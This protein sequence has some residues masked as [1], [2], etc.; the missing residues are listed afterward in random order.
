MR[1]A[2]RSAIRV[3]ASLV[4]PVA[5][6]V[7]A[8]PVTV[9]FALGLAFWSPT[10]T[11]GLALGA[12]FVGLAARING[13][14]LAAS[15]MAMDTL[16]LAISALVGSACAGV[17][18]LHVSTLVVWCFVGGLVVAL[19]PARSVVGIQ[20]VMAIIVFGRA[21]HSVGASVVLAVAVLLGGAVQTAVQLVVRVPFGL[22]PQRRAT[23]LV[24]RQLAELAGGRREGRQEGSSPAVALSVDRAQAMLGSGALFGRPD[25]QALRGMVDEAR[26]MRLELI[27]IGGLLRRLP[28]EPGTEQ[29]I[30]RVRKKLAL[31]LLALSDAV[32]SSGS[33]G[34]PPL[35][36]G[37]GAWQELRQAM[38]VLE[39]RIELR[40]RAGGAAAVVLT[41]FRSLRGQIRAATRLVGRATD[42]PIGSILQV[43]RPRTHPVVADLRTIWG[44]LA[45]NLTTTSPAFRHAV[46]LAV[47]VPVLDVAFQHSGLARSYWIPLSA[48]VVLR[49]DYTATMSR[50]LARVGGTVVG[51]GAVGAIVGGLH[52]G[53]AAVVALVA[54]TGWGAFSLYQSSYAVGVAFLTGLVLMLAGVGQPATLALAGYRLLDSV[55][56]GSVALVAYLLWPTWSKAEAQQS[57][58]R[59]VAAQ[60]RYVSAVLAGLTTEPPRDPEELRRLGRLARLAYIDAQS[61]VGRSLAEPPAKRIDPEVS[62]GILVA[63]RRMIR[64]AHSLRTETA[65]PPTLAGID[66][67]ADAVDRSFAT[68]EDGLEGNMSVDALPPLRDMYHRIDRGSADAPAALPVLI[69]LDEMINAVDTVGQ[70]MCARDQD[71]RA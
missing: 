32:I 12:L 8:V 15:A 30:D 55:I 61:A 23:A 11:S 3:D 22:R 60:R 24:Y 69:Q 19:G 66:R 46:R 20:G 5:G 39:A 31:F 43:G 36:P 21:P 1:H 64:A 27:A 53:T 35:D 29:A 59:L 25:A 10:I 49:P 45:E 2:V 33:R 9:L 56:G 44:V 57:L 65:V 13:P 34:H 68:V 71:D 16:G 38:D 48:A 51:V 54:L 58:A 47:V 37:A 40:P 41:H 63:L 17:A 42:V 70:L 4:T 14:R 7:T 28:D 26:R 52:P 67:F 18:W 6:A 50:G 62:Q